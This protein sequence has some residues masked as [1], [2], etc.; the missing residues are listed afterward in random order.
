[1]ILTPLEQF[2]IVSFFS[3]KLF[4]L[5]FSFT[6]LVLI[7]I[8]VLGIYVILVY[9]LSNTSTSNKHSTS[10]CFIP[11]NWQTL[12]ELI[13][14]T[15]AQL[16]YDNINIE[17][18]KYFPFVSAIFTFILF[19]NLIGLIPNSFTIT[20][21]LIVTFTL[22]FPIF[23]GI[24]NDIF[25]SIKLFCIELSN[26]VLLKDFVV[27]KVKLLLVLLSELGS[28]TPDLLEEGSMGE[29]EL[30]PEIWGDGLAPDDQVEAPDPA[31]APAPDPEPE[32]VPAPEP[33]PEPEPAQDPASQQERSS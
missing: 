5:D 18:K 3:I 11:N 16:L 26:L 14:E 25:F 21:H 17:G 22:S 31:P 33:V 8:L 7:N 30:W 27:S 4:C 24:Y 1:M 20:S 9:C 19:S 32:Q 13:Y 10:L 2:Q 28:G 23:I 12:I 15:T 6:N 29:A